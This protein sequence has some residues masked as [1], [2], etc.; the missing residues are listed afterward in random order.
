MNGR[1]PAYLIVNA[2]DYAYYDCVSRGILQCAESGIVTA[3]GVFANSPHLKAHAPWLASASGL[4]SG[5]HLNITDRRPV[6]RAM[7]DRLDR[8]DGEFP[9]KFAMAKALLDGA[10][11]RTLV[12]DEW[13]AQIECCL[14]AGL[15]PKFLNS[16]EH[17]HMFPGLY[18]ITVDL[19]AEYGI[20]HLRHA[21]PEW[22]PG[23]GVSALLRDAIMALLSATN[24]HRCRRVAPRFMGMGES[25]RLSADYLQRIHKR[26]RPGGIYELMCHPG[27]FDPEEVRDE[28]LLGY[29]D[30]EQERR[31]L[32]ESGLRTLLKDNQVELIGYRHLQ[33]RGGELQV[34]KEETSR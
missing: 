16:H 22:P 10:V 18:P 14:D 20:P 11:P 7:E 2:D 34:V 28:R 13:R 30:W 8:Y 3:T 9:G 21:A 33:I 29:H 32:S 6:T 17:M 12:K 31:N 27:Y 24:Y 19:A 1:E 5:V 26:L 23:P 4:D 25:G 15:Q